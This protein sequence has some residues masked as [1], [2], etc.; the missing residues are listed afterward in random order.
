MHG[1][2]SACDNAIPMLQYCKSPKK[3]IPRS[4]DF[5]PGVIDIEISHRS[6]SHLLLLVL[7][8]LLTFG[9]LFT[10]PTVWQCRYSS[11]RNRPGAVIFHRRHYPS[12]CLAAALA[13]SI[14]RICLWRPIGSGRRVFAGPA[15][16]SAGG[17]V[18]SRCFRRGCGGRVVGM[19]L[20]W[21]VLLV[22]LSSLA[23]ALAVLRW[24]SV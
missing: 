1:L 11:F 10:G 15:S 9:S 13:A 22:N 19:L 4:Q 7:F 23:G 14:G 24:C 16:Q 20:G 2:S 6:R 3:R 8:F 5:P 21:G 12:D 17:S 18:Y